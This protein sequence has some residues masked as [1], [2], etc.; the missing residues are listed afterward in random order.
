M[1][2]HVVTARR[3]FNQNYRAYYPRIFISLL[4]LMVLV[5]CSDNA[6]IAAAQAELS[7]SDSAVPVRVARVKLQGSEQVLRFAGVSRP[8][9]RAN[10]S[11]Q[12]GGTIEV[13]LAEIGQRVSKGDIVARLYNPQL[14]PA[15]N[16]AQARLEQLQS[17]AE[18]DRRDLSRLQQI[19]ERDLLSIQELETQR[20]KLQS[21]LS[22]ID[23]ARALLSQNQQLQQESE[24]RA[25]FNG[26]IEAVLLEPGEFAQPGQPAIRMAAEDGL[27]VEVRV[28]PHLLA[29]LVTGQTVPLWHSLSG[30]KFSGS[31][32]EIGESSSGN[33]ALYPLIVALSEA[34]LRSG[35]AL[36]VGVSQPQ[37]KDLSIPLNAV[38]R[39]AQGLTVFK[40]HND[41]VQRV[42]VK[43]NQINGDQVILAAGSLTVDDKVVYAGITRLADGDKVE[44]LQ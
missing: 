15:A 2:H 16:A 29:S 13:R 40:L 41:R 43:V 17:D 14:Q 44:L 9:Q 3:Q 4:I 18:Q 5:R 23:N 36:Q 12:V 27:E 39:S 21:T 7:P 38:M 8:R 32:S 24:L 37:S 28:P 1:F 11:F 10:L 33:S 26:R 42:D 31:I 30:E 6:G 19:Y 35:E 34:G 20:T 22:A 25:P